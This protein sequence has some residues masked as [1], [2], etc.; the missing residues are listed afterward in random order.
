MQARYEIL[1]LHVNG[2]W[3]WE[4]GRRCA[5]ATG[6]LATLLSLDP[7]FHAIVMHGVTDQVTPYYASKMLIDQMPA[8]GDPSRLRLAVY[9]GGHMPYIEDEP[10]AAMREDARKL[11]AGEGALSQR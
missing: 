11:I 6:D 5:E 4:N 2:S 9:G 8:F 1:N 10:R 7:H 3:D